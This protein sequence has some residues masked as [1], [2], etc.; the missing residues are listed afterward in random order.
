M[1]AER[2]AKDHSPIKSVATFEPG[3]LHSLLKLCGT[4]PGCK[5]GR[6]RKEPSY[7]HWE[8]AK[9]SIDC[10]GKVWLEASCAIREVGAE[11]MGQTI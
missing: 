3:C 8:N 4:G 5:M 7:L 11:S 1:S 2:Q 10:S 6:N 9:H